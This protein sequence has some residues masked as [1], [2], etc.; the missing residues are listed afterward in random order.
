MDLEVRNQKKEKY[1]R[2]D[3]REHIRRKITTYKREESNVD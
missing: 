1:L 2:V 3:V